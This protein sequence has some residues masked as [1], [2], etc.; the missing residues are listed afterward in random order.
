VSNVGSGPLSR[1]CLFQVGARR[2]PLVFVV[3]LCLFVVVH[4]TLC[5]VLFAGLPN[6]CWCLFCGSP[7][8]V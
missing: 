6:V 5:F 8:T 2:P 4:F 3:S 7:A 1:G